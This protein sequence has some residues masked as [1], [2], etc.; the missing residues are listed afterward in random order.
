MNSSESLKQ[1]ATN[2]GV[3]HRRQHTQRESMRFCCAPFAVWRALSHNC[4]TNMSPRGDKLS[5][6]QKPWPQSCQSTPRGDSKWVAFKALR[7]LKSFVSLPRS[8]KAAS[9]STVITSGMA[10]WIFKKPKSAI[11]PRFWSPNDNDETKSR[12]IQNA[13]IWISVARCYFR[14]DL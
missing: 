11:F 7:A 2:C 4:A 6:N 14:R 10:I 13:L 8:R 5:A 3:P 1:A 9:P 12:T